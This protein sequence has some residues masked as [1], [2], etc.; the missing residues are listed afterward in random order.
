MNNTTINTT[1]TTNNTTAFY[2]LSKEAK[3]LVSNNIALTAHQF[4]EA[5]HII[6][7]PKRYEV[8]DI[9]IEEDAK[10]NIDTTTKIVSLSENPLFANYSVSKRMVV[11]SVS[12]LMHE[13]YLEKFVQIKIDSK[14]KN[15][16]FIK[17]VSRKKFLFFI[18]ITE[19]KV[20]V[21]NNGRFYDLVSHTVY[22]KLTPNAKAYKMLLFSA[23]DARNSRALYYKLD[24]ANESSRTII[25]K[26]APGLYDEMAGILTK[27]DGTKFA[28]RTGMLKTTGKMSCYLD[29]FIVLNNYVLD[30]V[31]D[32]S[33]GYALS[34]ARFYMDTFGVGT[35]ADAC[36]ISTQSRM[37]LSQKFTDIVFQ[38]ELFEE[39]VETIVKPYI[40]ENAA[41]SVKK[42]IVTKYYNSKRRLIATIVGDIDKAT[43]IFDKNTT[44]AKVNYDREITRGLT[45]MAVS[46][47]SAGHLNSQVNETLYAVA[48]RQTYELI[49][50][51]N[52]FP[53]YTIKDNNGNTKKV[54]T[55]FLLNA[56]LPMEKL[57]RFYDNLMDKV[58]TKE[59]IDAIFKESQNPVMGDNYDLSILGSKCPTNPVVAASRISS[60]MDTIKNNIQGLSFETCFDDDSVSSFNMLLSADFTAVFGVRVIGDDCVFNA[61]IARMIEKMGKDY[62]N[63]FD[64]AIMTK[65][66]KTGIPEYL[67]AHFMTFDEIDTAID[68][69]EISDSLKRMF[70][71]KFH[72][73]PDGVIYFPSNKEVFGTLAGSDTD[74]DKVQAYF[75]KYMVNQCT[76]HVVLRIDTTH[77]VDETAK[78]T[79]LS[80]G[81]A[82]KLADTMIAMGKN[83]EETGYDDNGKNIG[84]TVTLD[85]DFIGKMYVL[86]VVSQL[87]I[88]QITFWNN[89]I[90]MLL[91]EAYLGRLNN[92]K[93]F[94]KE[95]GISEGFRDEALNIDEDAV[96]NEKY[97]LNLR[98]RMG[99]V[100]W[101]QENIIEFLICCNK[102]FRLYQEGAIDA[103]KTGIYIDIIFT[104]ESLF[105]E[106]LYKLTTAYEDK[107]RR[108]AKKYITRDY[109]SRREFCIVNDVKT[110]VVEFVDEFAKT[111]NRLMER[112]NTEFRSFINENANKFRYS[113]AEIDAFA[114]T[115]AA[116]EE[117]DANIIR[118]LYNIKIVYNSIVARRAKLVMEDNYTPEDKEIFKNE[119]DELS[120]AIR[121]ILD[122]TTL[123]DTQ[124]ARLVLGIG[125]SY[126]V[127]DLKADSTNKFAY[128]LCK[129]LVFP[130]FMGGREYTTECGIISKG[131]H[132]DGQTV[133]VSRGVS[134]YGLILDSKYTGEVVISGNRAYCNNSFDIKNTDENKAMLVIKK[135]D[136]DMTLTRN[137]SVAVGDDGNVYFYSDVTTDCDAIIIG[138]I[139]GAKIF[140]GKIEE[141]YYVDIVSEAFWNIPV[142][143]EYEDV[144]YIVMYLSK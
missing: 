5:R 64:I 45:I 61:G 51:A 8:F 140:T 85:D 34:K 32:S 55:N 39:Y 123:D 133:S 144:P 98:S 84:E 23:G 54:R 29:N 88:G 134:E 104:C 66:P 40:K 11:T 30:L 110:K 86:N 53:T 21:R 96:I 102:I 81:Y 80:S 3:S 67:R 142:N 70:K 131:N 9:T 37:G 129:E 42:G 49:N 126:R 74:G 36:K 17:R 109:S 119:L 76:E 120:N 18:D 114:D 143:G 82:K 141:D 14:T 125:C 26:V 83:I 28:S 111:E 113:D 48:A 13:N 137:S 38:D 12:S 103:T 94:L 71:F 62:D 122:K 79:N 135:T 59:S 7:S 1:N 20:F 130:Y 68:N 117:S 52:N 99:E 4:I 47:L 72:N 50:D 41:S 108:I 24:Y 91:V 93:T 58:M 90:I 138:K 19:N 16:D 65:A 132:L 121:V 10:G 46:H 136:I 69:I 22:N 31:S 25:N 128:T 73:S 112:A 77:Y 56:E 63:R 35:Q 15:K 106:R 87:S 2:C 95:C 118:S 27:K 115:L 57:N 75:D 124:K 6:T 78:N 33:D 105:I 101:T 97:A 139:A 116:V 100:V 127:S 60:K 107:T 44:K 43:H 89:K 92:V